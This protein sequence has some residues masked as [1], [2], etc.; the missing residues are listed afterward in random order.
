MTGLTILEKCKLEVTDINLSD[1]WVPQFYA[2]FVRFKYLNFFKERKKCLSTFSEL[3]TSGIY[4]IR[5]QIKI[6]RIDI[7]TRNQ[8]LSF[9]YTP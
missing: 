2:Q 6:Y 3:W 5:K 4:I 9:S 1:G 8:S 7:W